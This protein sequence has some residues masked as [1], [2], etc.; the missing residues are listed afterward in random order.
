[1]G[2][3]APIWLPWVSNV[4]ASAPAHSA[5]T[6][7][8][9]MGAWN[10]EQKPT[11]GPSHCRAHALTMKSRDVS[12][13]LLPRLSSKQAGVLSPFG[14]PAPTIEMDSLS[15]SFKQGEESRKTPGT[16]GARKRQAGRLARIFWPNESISSMLD[17][18]FS[19]V[20]A[21]WNMMTR[22]CFCPQRHS[23]LF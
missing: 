14:S 11:T 8:G 13:F 22:G 7:P 10:V 17:T 18:S 4:L 5:P 16:S 9:R 23:D 15:K 12:F 19:R 6:A 20:H 21:T 2:Q 3:G 1:M